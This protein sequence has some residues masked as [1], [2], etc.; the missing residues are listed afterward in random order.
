MNELTTE[1]PYELNKDMKFIDE[2]DH[3]A[4]GKVIHVHE[5]KKNLDL[6]VKVI[7]KVGAGMQ[8]IKKMKEEVAILKKLNHNNVV[9][10]YGYSETNNQLLI[11]MEYIKYGTL[12]RWMKDHHKISENDASIIIGKVLSAVEYLH[13]MHICHRDIKPE[14]I[15]ISKENDLESIKIIDFGLSAQHFNYLTNN[16]Y[17]GTFIYMAPEQIEKKLYYHSVDIWSIGI[18]MYMLLN[19]GKHPFYQKD[20]KKADF[21]NKIKLAKLHFIN[22]ISYM[23]KHLMHKLCE[24]NPSWRY[25]ANLAIKHPWITRNPNDDIPLTFNEILNKNNNKKNAFSLIM[26]NIFLNY[27]KKNNKFSN[28]NNNENINNFDSFIKKKKI[29]N[30]IY[31]INNDYIKQCNI[32]NKKQKERIQKMRERYLEVV[33]TDEE[34]SYEKKKNHNTNAKPLKKNNKSSEKYI[35]PH[36]K[37]HEDETEYEYSNRF[38]KYNNKKIINNRKIINLYNNDFPIRNSLYSNLREKNKSIHLLSMPNNKEKKENVNYNKK[39][40]SNKNINSIKFYNINKNKNTINTGK[41]KSISKFFV[42]KNSPNE[43]I[44]N[45][46]E[47]INEKEYKENTPEKSNR[48]SI[49]KS[50]KANRYQIKPNLPYVSNL[51]SQFNNNTSKKYNNNY[52]EKYNITPV[53]LPFIGVKQDEKKNKMI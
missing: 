51:A 23:A 46:N 52:M 43:E 44:N 5:N 32:I 18:L 45:Q 31:K 11:K 21:I 29:K 4:F 6:A 37:Y 15:M 27:I 24:P 35:S 48:L 26:I 3:G 36:K 8:I 19:N 25:S 33:S 7:N 42:N 17:C 2:I 53:V 1:S 49:Y 22:K 28:N 9:K 14:N 16:D 50:S 47:I 40:T 20:D 30:K 38:H 34:D 10:F 13:S 39:I 41:S 12:S